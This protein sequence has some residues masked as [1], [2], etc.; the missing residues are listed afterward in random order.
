MPFGWPTA[1]RTP[2]KTAAHQ[3]RSGGVLEECWRPAFARSL[4]PKYTA[5]RR[6]LERYIASFDFDRAHLGRHTQ[7][8]TPAEVVYGSRKMRPR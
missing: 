8:R 5:L 2:V 7:G 4:V 1:V 3:A 6:D